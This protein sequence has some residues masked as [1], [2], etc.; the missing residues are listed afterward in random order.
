MVQ[1]NLVPALVD[2]MEA[3]GLDCSWLDSNGHRNSETMLLILGTLLE[4]P[5]GKVGLLAAKFLM[6]HLHSMYIY[7]YILI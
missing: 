3:I 1:A 5:A 2:G 4:L 6:V 7:I